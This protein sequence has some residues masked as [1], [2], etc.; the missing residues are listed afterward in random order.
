[1]RILIATDGNIASE[2]AIEMLLRMP[3][4]RVTEI[5]LL[6]VVQTKRREHR[7]SELNAGPLLA[8]PDRDDLSKNREEYARAEE[9]LRNVAHRLRSVADDVRTL[10][11][12]GQPAEEILR[13]AEGMSVDLIVI[14][15][16]GRTGG[17]RWLLGSISE[18]VL[19]RATCPVLLVKPWE[20][21][22]MTRLA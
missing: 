9:M 13:V 19:R 12:V 7:W 21:K 14:G 16:K 3:L 11:E 15:N 8:L 22:V 18:K 20:I 5:I 10:V 2:A 6:T 17:S 4:P 1:M